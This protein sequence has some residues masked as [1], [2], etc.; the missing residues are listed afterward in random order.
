MR[1]IFA[2]SLVLLLVASIAA[3]ACLEILDEFIPPGTVNVP[4]SHQMSAYG[5]S[6]TYTWSIWAGSLPSGLS[7]SSSGLISGTP[8][9]VEYTLVYVRVTDSANP[10]CTDTRA[11]FVYV[12]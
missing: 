11:Y 6:G 8:T 9:T 2:V 10:S 12:D 7:M 1:K 4:Y 5:G 3:A